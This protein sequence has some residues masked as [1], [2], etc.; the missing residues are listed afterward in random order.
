MASRQVPVRLKT[1]SLNST[2][3]R[4]TCTL[5]LASQYP[6]IKYHPLST[7]Y[8]HLSSAPHRQLSSA[9]Q[10]SSAATFDTARPPPSPPSPPPAPISPDTSHPL[11]C[12][13]LSVL[14]RNIAITS[15]TSNRILLPPSLKLLSAIA[16]STHPLLRPSSNPL[17]R[18]LLK[19]TL[20]AQFCAGE[21]P[22]EVR[23]TLAGLRRWGIEGILL[24][25][26]REVEQRG[27]GTYESSSSPLV[28]TEADKREI[29]EWVAGTQQAL[30]MASARDCVCIKF[31]GT[32]AL[33][34]TALATNRPPTPTLASGLEEVAREARE[35]D[36]TLVVDAEQQAIQ[37]GI[38]AWTLDLARRFNTSRAFIVGTYQA[39]LKAT[40]Q[41][42]ADDL[43]EASRGGFALGIKLVRGAYLGSD[44]REL[45]HD[46]KEDT[47]AAYD[48][49]A[50]GIMRRSW[51]L[52]PPPTSPAAPGK[53]GLKFPEVCLVLA[54]HN[55]TSS[56]R[57]MQIRAGQAANH[58]VRVPMVYAQLMG[59]A[60]HVSCELVARRRQ[61]DKETEVVRVGKGSG[62][63]RLDQST[64]RHGEE[65]ERPRPYK[66]LVWGSVDEC[67][68][69]LVRRAEENRDA[70]ARTEEGRVLLWKELR[71]RVFG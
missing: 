48:R 67:L 62:L 28:E 52:L 35:R 45:M 66:Y 50:E 71:R 10:T 22:A 25:W 56:R 30:A 37:A 58:E 23:A 5:P 20:F 7:P 9:P 3:I 70:V 57:A 11:S 49:V 6:I 54:T 44:P 26:A 43:A 1:L 40:P 68:K 21:T 47:D 64:G 12:L 53:E 18:Y 51:T 65:V 36:I 16:Y 63:H 32:G 33:N 4:A 13:P 69:Y 42:L 34:L 27:S 46:C 19:R 31:T 61:A 2:I 8:R 39:Y 15:L 41:R 29:E 38:Y 59:M 24:G 17:L 60:D 14:V 55:S